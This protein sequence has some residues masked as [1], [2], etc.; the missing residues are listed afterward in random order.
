MRKRI[1][2]AGVLFLMFCLT[3]LP[4]NAKEENSA[5]EEQ[6]LDEYAKF[7]GD[8][9][10]KNLEEAGV[11]DFF[12]FAP[13]LDAEEVIKQLNTGKLNLSTEQVLKY[14]LKML[15]GEVSSGARLVA[16]VLA[17][18]VLSSYLGGLKSGFGGESVA[19]CAFYM[20][21][22][23]IAGIASTAFY[24]IALCAGRTIENI[25]FFMRV[26]VPVMITLLMTSG[27]VISAS[28]LE[29][30]F[31]S[32]AEIA[33][34]VIE[35]VFI[36][37]V[38]LSTAL[39]IVNGIS[40]R[41]KTERMVKLLNNS[42]KWGLTI[43]LTIFVSLAGLKSIAASGADGLTVKL[44]KFATSNLIPMVGGVL[45]ESVETVMNCSVVI[46]NSVGVLGVICLI[47]VALVPIMKIAAMLIL[48]RITAAVAE[49]VS[50]ERIVVCLSRLA[51]SVSVLFSM[52]TAVV[53]M[54]IMVVTIIINSG[55]TAVMLGR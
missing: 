30:A 44:G 24:D 17:L 22:I 12:E 21:Y 54:F 34:W 25:G 26:I 9:F 37:A 35:T 40:D 23:I 46:K 5:V 3:E 19:K 16:I 41:F 52:L 20:C 6:M 55:N 1:I 45:A 28:T 36:P 42:V 4:I 29:P 50:E 38:M 48:F 14:L 33:V 2:L 51:D 11:E 53:I 39:N 7:Y 49:P 13:E 43:M 32:I 31:L 10:E 18:S 15:L 27:A 47:V 8:I